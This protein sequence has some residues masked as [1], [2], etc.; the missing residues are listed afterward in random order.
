MDNA[1]TDATAEVVADLIR[2]YP[3]RQLRYLFEPRLGKHYAQH[4]GARAAQAKL[5][6]YTDDDVEVAPT[7]VQAYIDA[8]A[9]NPQMDAGGGPVWP[10]WEIDPPEWLRQYIRG[11][12]AFGP[13]ATMDRGDSF[14]LGANGYFFGVN[15]ALPYEALERF[16]GFRPDL[17][18]DTI[19]GSGEWGL[20][21]AMQNAGALIGYVPAA[22][23]W[24]NVPIERMQ[25][26]YLER[27]AWIGS[28]ADMF[29]RWH[30]RPR[31]ART[32]VSEVWHIILSYW[33]PWL[34]ATITVRR[35]NAT[36][37]RIRS[38]ASSGWCELAYVWW[39]V[40]RR[41]LREFLDTERFGP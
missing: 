21:K 23:V 8:F 10:R 30:G 27:W 38:H 41:D 36:A 40:S 18:G 29:E 12:E 25:P 13:F 19:F 39:I 17:V 5:L 35:P 31:H 20:V 34:R 22:G 4:L 6:L 7:W 24:H 9:E 11:L 1:S 3:D 16:G 15:M 26:Q 32:L 14:L 33:R 37:A 28:A 2:E